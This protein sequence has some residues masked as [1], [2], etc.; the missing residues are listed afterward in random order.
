MKRKFFHDQ[1]RP[2]FW[3]RKTGRFD[4]KTGLQK[5]KTGRFTNAPATGRFVK[6]PVFLIERPVVLPCAL[7][8]TGLFCVAIP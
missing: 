5:W 7:Q 3:R 2:V 6:R 1:K 4:R 8:K